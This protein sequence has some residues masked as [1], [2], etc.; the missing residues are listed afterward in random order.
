MVG[1]D[2][3]ALFRCEQGFRRIKRYDKIAG[4]IEVIEREQGD[5]ASAAA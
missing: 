2:V 3:G 5:L 1:T 4:L